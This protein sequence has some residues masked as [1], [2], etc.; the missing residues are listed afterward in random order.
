L[1]QEKYQEEYACDKRHDDDDDDNNNNKLIIII[2]KNKCQTSGS[3]A[4]PIIR[5]S[6]GIVN[7]RQEEL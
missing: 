6:F 7:W 2:A 3:L 1:F 5:P 4:V